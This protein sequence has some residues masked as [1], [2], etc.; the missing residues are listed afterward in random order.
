MLACLVAGIVV[1]DELQLEYYTSAQFECDDTM[2]NFTSSA[3]IKHRY[4][5][6]PS[7]ELI[8]T[9][10]SDAHITIDDNFALTVDK[11]EDEDFGHYFCLLVRDDFTVDRIVHGLNTGGP[12]YGD[13]FE[14]YTQKAMIG[15]IAAGTLFVIVAGSCLVWTFRHRQRDQRNRAVDELDKTIN[16]FDMKS[17][18]NV[19]ADVEDVKVTVTSRGAEG[20]G[21]DKTDP[22]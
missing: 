14:K 10:T 21:K 5:L 17:Y 18:D 7:G 20:N 2:Y 15:G 16:G 1:C 13:L 6:L 9:N 12:F 19:G 8:V 4:W 11:I 22:V 3:D